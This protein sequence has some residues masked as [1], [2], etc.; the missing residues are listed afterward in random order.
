MIDSSDQVKDLGTWQPP[1]VVG[2]QGSLG[3]FK[4]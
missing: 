4:V 2:G 1:G 3:F